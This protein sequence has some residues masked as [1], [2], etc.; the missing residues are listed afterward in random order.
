MRMRKRGTH[1]GARGARWGPAARCPCH[2]SACHTPESAAWCRYPAVDDHALCLPYGRTGKPS[3]RLFKLC[4]FS[5]VIYMVRRPPKPEHKLEAEVVCTPP[6]EAQHVCISRACAS[7][8]AMPVPVVSLRRAECAFSASPNPRY[9]VYISSCCCH[10]AQVAFPQ[11]LSREHVVVGCTQP[12]CAP[13]KP[14]N[15][16]PPDKTTRLAVSHCTASDRSTI[17]LKHVQTGHGTAT[18][19]TPTMI[20]TSDFLAQVSTCEGSSCSSRLRHMQLLACGQLAQTQ[21]RQQLHSALLPTATRHPLHP[22]HNAL[23][24]ITSMTAAPQHRRAY[25]R[26]L[27]APRHQ[28]MRRVQL[29]PSIFKRAS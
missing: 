1:F 8:Q 17:C 6:A 23:H 3:R 24:C 10:V 13:L 5:A 29:A 7:V 2:R 15:P 9:V 28:D 4:R 26:G 14:Q 25:Q 12:C 16:L 22:P 19:Y 27:H 18:A 11:H 21:P 20:Y